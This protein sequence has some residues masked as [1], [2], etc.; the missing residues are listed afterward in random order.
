MTVRISVAPPGLFRSP[1]S[2]AASHFGMRAM[3]AFCVLNLWTPATR[4]GAKIA[5]LSLFSLK[6]STFAGKYG[7]R[8]TLKIGY[9]PTGADLSI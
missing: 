1:F 7:S 9:F 8:E 2:A 5:S 6:L 3:L 4:W